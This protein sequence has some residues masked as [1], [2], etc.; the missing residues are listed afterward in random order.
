MADG[1]MPGAKLRGGKNNGRTLAKAMRALGTRIR[2]FCEG[3][4]L[5]VYQNG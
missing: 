5:T 2:Y 1:C 4:E 3:L